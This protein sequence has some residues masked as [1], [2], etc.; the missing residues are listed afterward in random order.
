MMKRTTMATIALMAGPAMLTA[1]QT[2]TTRTRADSAQAG[3][4]QQG[5]RG[6]TSRPV[7]Q[8]NQAGDTTRSELRDSLLRANQMGE[9]AAAQQGQQDSTQQGQMQQRSGRMN[10]GDMNLTR[11][12]IIQLQEA[13][14]SRGYYAPA[15]DGEIGPNTRA[16]MDRARQELGV[17]T[18]DNEALFK[19]LNLDFQG[20]EGMAGQGADS[21][22]MA[23]PADTSA[24]NVFNQARPQGTSDSTTTRPDST[25]PNVEEGITQPSEIP[26]DSIHSMQGAQPGRPVPLTNEDGDTATSALRD[27]LLR[28]ANQPMRADSTQRDST[29]QMNNMQRDSTEMDTKQERGNQ[30]EAGVVNATTGASTLGRDVNKTRP[31]QGQP[32]TS[33]GDTVKQ[34]GDSASTRRPPR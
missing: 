10:R 21:S 17:N 5:A 28:A 16:A 13:L 6:D 33:K 29:Q 31:D 34:G 23:V 32:T 9:P 14:R 19:A 24:T 1:Q 7:N 27:S 18:N 30:T 4:Q 2:D 15:S 26:R 20:A 25:R 3:V 11:E 8:M 22:N 12:Q